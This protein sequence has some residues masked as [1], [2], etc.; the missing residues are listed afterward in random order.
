MSAASAVLLAGPDRWLPVLGCLRW[1]E[2]WPA[3]R[4]SPEPRRELCALLADPR[5][6]ARFV[7]VGK[8]T[9]PPGAKGIAISRH[10]ASSTQA[11]N[12][13]GKVLYTGGWAGI[14]VATRTCIIF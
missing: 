4:G 6:S 3:I 2:I 9:T 10:R 7:E 8:G 5:A 14:W 11:R 12:D 13:R 1:T